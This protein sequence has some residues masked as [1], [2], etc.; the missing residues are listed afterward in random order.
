MHGD[1]SQG[2]RERALSSFASGRTPT[3]I[4]TDVAAR[5]IDVSGITHVVNFDLPAAAEDYVHR[6]GRT[7]RAG[8]SGIGITFVADDQAPDAAK[9]GA[10]LGLGRELAAAGI[11]ARR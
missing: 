5:G 6:V 10:Q 9:M 2:Q 7:A 4:A 1:K 11:K 8:S 3:L